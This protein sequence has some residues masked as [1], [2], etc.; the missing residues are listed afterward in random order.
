MAAKK[1]GIIHL[2]N[3][4]AVAYHRGNGAG[5]SR[6]VMVYGLTDTKTSASM[7]ATDDSLHCDD[8]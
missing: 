3:D 7:E 5:G 2:T 4:S 6:E 1:I 8:V